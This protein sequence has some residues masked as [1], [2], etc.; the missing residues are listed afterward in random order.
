MAGCSCGCG[1]MTLVTNA[2]ESCGCGCA[3]CAAEPKGR[4]E[5]IHE[6][7][8]LREAIERRLSELSAQ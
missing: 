6:L 5:E 3:C 8:N 1:E 4:E 7:T 2:T